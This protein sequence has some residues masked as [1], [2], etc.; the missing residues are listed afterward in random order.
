MVTSGLESGG[1][2][3]SRFWFSTALII[4]LSGGLYRGFRRRD[5]L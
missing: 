1:K 4:V 2:P 5:W 3:G